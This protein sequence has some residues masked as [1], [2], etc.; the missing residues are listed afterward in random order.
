MIRVKRVYEPP[1][2]QDGERLLVDRLWPRGI[3]RDSL[4]LG[5][6][7]KD[8]APTQALRRWFGH[9]AAR[10]QEF[11]E[12]YFAELDA[13]PSAW[14]NVL[15]RAQRGTVTLLYGARDSER[16]NAVAL[17]LYL[18]QREKQRGQAMKPCKDPPSKRS[19]QD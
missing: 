19:I 18:E 3:Q 1:S 16:N 9:D 17:K 4:R 6:W 12:R 7:L 5:G 8:V 2:S 14:R 13:K 11:Q 15:A 10:W